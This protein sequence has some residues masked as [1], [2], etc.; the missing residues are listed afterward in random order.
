[1][2]DGNN[3]YAAPAARLEPVVAADETVLAGRG[4]RL[5]AHIVDGLLYA[6]GFGPIYAWMML[7]STGSPPGNTFGEARRCVHD[8]IAD[9][10]VVQA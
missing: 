4:I 1:M 7:Q 5:V 3:P 10:I 2:E 8:L 9:T 6:L